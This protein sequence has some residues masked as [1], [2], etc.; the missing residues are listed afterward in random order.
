MH[1]VFSSNDAIVTEHLC[2]IWNFWS[3]GLTKSRKWC[4]CYEIDFFVFILWEKNIKGV[5]SKKGLRH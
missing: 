5:A 1:H 4:V 2:A 3:I